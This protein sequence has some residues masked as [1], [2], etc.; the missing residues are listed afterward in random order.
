MIRASTS[1]RRRVRFERIR[2]R[3]DLYAHEVF[4]TPPFDGLLVSKG[5]VDGW[6]TSGG[7]YSIAQ[8]HR[9]LRLGV[10]R[11]FRLQGGYR[12]TLPVIGDCGA[13]TYARESAP[14]YSVDDVL[15]FYEDCGF[16]GG[17]SVDHVILAY[18]EEWDRGGAPAE[19]KERQE[20]T[21]QLAR[22]FWRAHQRQ[23][24][25]FKPLG[26]AQGWSPRSYARAVRDLQKIG[27]DYVAVGG[28]VPLKTPQ[29]VAA[30]SAIN[31][32]RRKPTRLHLLG[33]TRL[34]QLRTFR[35]MGAVS[36][37]STSPL[38]QAF[39][40]DTDNFY[41]LDRTFVALRIPQVEGNPRLQKK[42]RAG[43]VDHDRARRLERDCLESVAA[44]DRG[45]KSARSVAALL[46]EY[47]QLLG[48]RRDNRSA[49]EE[50][51]EVAPW[52]RCPCN[53]CRRI[54][55]H[56]ILFRGAER[57]RRR[58]FH[59]VWVFYQRLRRELESGAPASPK[60]AKT[61]RAKR[62]QDDPAFTAG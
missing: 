15:S 10:R 38:R 48:G 50:V 17:V 24:L 45:K 61:T 53:V 54:G 43:Q 11:F 9:L 6:G 19:L 31:E 8:R 52:K 59:N 46:V 25:R 49:Y 2:Q 42:I 23:K 39:K 30:L 21:I 44:L 18:D 5:I 12:D 3:D 40:D 36:F 55:H 4:S 20:I 29:I 7:R 56:V 47:E 34:D 28:M 14:P 16:D 22:D 57:N 37:D 51:L 35:E 27:Y 13:F 60:P 1:R 58:G 62:H 26:V 32:A 41:T 33:I